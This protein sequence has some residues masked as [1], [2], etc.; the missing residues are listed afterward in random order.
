[1][2]I[3]GVAVVAAVL[4]ASAA[5]AA[6]SIRPGIGIGSVRLGMADAQVR[7][8]LGKPPAAERRS[9]GF[10][11]VSAVLQYDGVATTIVL[12]GRRSGLRVTAVATTQARYRTSEGF[13][14]G[15]PE[16]TLVRRLGPAFRCEPLKTIPSESG[17]FISG[18][19]GWR[20]CAVAGP[21]DTITVWFTRVPNSLA[22]HYPF[23]RASEWRPNARVVTVVVRTA[24]SSATQYGL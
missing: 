11:R 3:F 5:G 16:A 6:P 24:A 20:R 12:D 10:G 21:R 13:G 18:R 7:A 4:T 17:P 23:V 1:M 9:M 15:T 19:Q 8:L 2:R 22:R 14:V